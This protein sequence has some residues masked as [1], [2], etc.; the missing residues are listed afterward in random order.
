MTKKKVK[1][2]PKKLLIILIII[3]V[4]IIGVLSYFMFFK[5]ESVKEAKVVSKIDNY[6]Y[7]LK[8]NKSDTY[9]KLFKELKTVLS[10]KVDEKEYAKVITKMFIVDFYSLNDRTAKTDVGGVDFVHKDVLENFILNA[11]DT[12][13]KYVESNIYKERKQKLPTV[14]KVT[15]SNVEKTTFSYNDKTDEDAYKVNANWT[16]KDSLSSTGYQDE[17]TF[18]YVHDGKKLVLVEISDTDESQE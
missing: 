10:G 12:F 11:E 8:S 9:K 3:F 1:R 5:K 17:A 18:I 6:G 13:Y 16:Y 14:D 4:I 15:I 2:K 7:V